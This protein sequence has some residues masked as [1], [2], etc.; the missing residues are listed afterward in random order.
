[1]LEEV[2]YN[3][4]QNHPLLHT[5]LRRLTEEFLLMTW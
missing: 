4:Y 5:F 3:I 1:M 2:T